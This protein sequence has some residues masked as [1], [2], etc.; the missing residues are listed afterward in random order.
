MRALATGSAIAKLA[1]LAATPIITRLNDPA[2]LGAMGSLAS[3]ILI[4]TP[5]ANFRY[6]NAIPIP[7]TD[8][9][10]AILAALC[11]ILTLASTLLLATITVIWGDA[12]LKQASLEPLIPY[13]WLIITGFFLLG[14]NELA[15]AWTLR[16]RGYAKVARS[17]AFQSI[18]GNS[19]KIGL[20]IGGFGTVGLLLGHVVQLGGGAFALLH[21]TL[22]QVR[23]LAR[24]LNIKKLRRTAKVFIDLPFLRFPSQLLL[25][26]SMQ[27]PVLF[28]AKIFDISVAGQLSLAL[29]TLMLPIH[30]F[31]ASMGNAYLNEAARIGR[32]RPEEV[33]Q[34][35]KSVVKRL[36]AISAPIAIVLALFSKPLFKVAFGPEWDLAGQF[37]SYLAIYFA[38]QFISAPINHTLTIFRRQQTLLAMN[39]VRFMLVSGIFISAGALGMDDAHTILI[40]SIAMASHYAFCIISVFVIIKRAK[41]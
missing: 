27:G 41:K 37:A 17:Q 39:F 29:S 16:N 23:R 11:I 8:R 36:A 12:L 19:V 4:I 9:S 6:V 18:A 31:S 1:G 24:S 34:L 20:S 32:G 38:L 10:A 28:C 14:L 15:V 2:A 25:V 5:L 7:R 33:F 3:L 21:T 35:T 30:L 40:Y 13:K 26:A 22:K